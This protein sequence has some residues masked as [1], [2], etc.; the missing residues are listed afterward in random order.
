MRVRWKESQRV[1]ALVNAVANQCF[2][3]CFWVKKSL[4]CYKKALIVRGTVILR[5]DDE[6][7]EEPHVWLEKNGWI[8]DPTLVLVRTEGDKFTHKPVRKFKKLPKV[9]QF[10]GVLVP[11]GDFCA[12]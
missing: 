3:N 6:S 12:D 7:W 2:T 11:L 4:E 9:G 5:I 10:C 1:A 8:I